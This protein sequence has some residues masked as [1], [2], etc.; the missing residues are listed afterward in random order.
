MTFHDR[1]DAGRQLA[2]A[3]REQAA[4]GA[5][6]ASALRVPALVL[7]LPRGGVPVAFEVARAFD[8]PLDVL[9][10]RKL[11]VPG[12]EELAFGAVAWGG[13]VVLNPGV[14]RAFALRPE[15][16]DRIAQRERQE[17]Q[18]REALYR[19][20]RPAL[21]VEGHPVILVD[22]GLATGATMLAAVRALRPRAAHI[23]V[24]VPVGSPGSCEELGREADAALC[25][26]RPDRFEAV[27]EFYRDFRQT[28][29][30][31]VADLLTAAQRSEPT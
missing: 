1:R 18:R 2:A 5:I 29:D 13:T 12:Q 22:D 20:G 27:G 26:E 16:I 6:P 11:G 23:L 8:L 9:I 7:A 15:E 30:Q 19:R 17:I 24:A 10:V 14:V 4:S 31:E 25:L 3:L 28:S 21:A